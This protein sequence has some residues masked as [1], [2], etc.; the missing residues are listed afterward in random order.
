MI[1]GD[2]TATQLLL[3]PLGRAPI[4]PENVLCATGLQRFIKGDSYPVAQLFL[5]LW[6]MDPFED[7]VKARTKFLGEKTSDTGNCLYDFRG[8]INFLWTTRGSLDL[9]PGSRQVDFLS[10]Q[11]PTLS[12]HANSHHFLQPC[13]FMLVYPWHCSVH[14]FIHSTS[15]V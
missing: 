13:E 8:F 10:A 11:F 9:L 7:L 14:G 6:I 15:L 1:L 2:K 5:I 12:P 4:A 3:F